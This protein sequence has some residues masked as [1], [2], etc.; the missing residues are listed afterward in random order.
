MWGQLWHPYRCTSTTPRLYMTIIVN[1]D[2]GGGATSVLRLYCGQKGVMNH[3]VDNCNGWCVEV[4]RRVGGTSDQARPRRGPMLLSEAVGTLNGGGWSDL[5]GVVYPND[6]GSSWWSIFYGGL[7]VTPPRVP[8]FQQ[9]WTHRRNPQG[10]SF[11]AMCSKLHGNQ[12]WRRSYCQ[13]GGFATPK[14]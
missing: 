1:G 13:R 8:T 14:L 5:C 11:A 6:G 2:V 4:V 12:Y 7:A 3:F 9:L 10:V